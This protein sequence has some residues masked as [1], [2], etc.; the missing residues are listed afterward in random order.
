MLKILKQIVVS[1]QNEPMDWYGIAQ[2]RKWLET[3]KAAAKYKT[4]FMEEQS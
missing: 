1:V 4:L 2:W 3:Y